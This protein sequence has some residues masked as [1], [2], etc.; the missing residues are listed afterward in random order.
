MDNSSENRKYLTLFSV[1]VLL[2]L[3]LGVIF[4]YF[5]DTGNEPTFYGSQLGVRIINPEHNSIINSSFDIEF[6]S[7]HSSFYACTMQHL[8][9][10]GEIVDNWTH[11]QNRPI[12]TLYTF[13]STTL[14]NG[15]HTIEVNVYWDIIYSRPGYPS[16]V[17][18][19]DSIYL[20]FE[21]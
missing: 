2:L 17:M 8:K 6:E 13:D 18:S 10:D 14:S 20:E 15:Q 21:N 16:R 7:W 5:S 11:N 12:P 3:I 4:L 9:V 19:Y 1:V